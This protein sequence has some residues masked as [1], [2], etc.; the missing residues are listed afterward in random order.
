[1]VA[2]S[3]AFPEWLTYGFDSDQIGQVFVLLA[4]NSTICIRKLRFVLSLKEEN[5]IS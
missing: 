1:M 4:V 2:L 3:Y 5:P